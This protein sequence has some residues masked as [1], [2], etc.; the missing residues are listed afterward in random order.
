[1]QKKIKTLIPNDKAAERIVNMKERIVKNS[2]FA[3][4]SLLH[5]C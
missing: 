4:L 1:M 2:K 5:C 3:R